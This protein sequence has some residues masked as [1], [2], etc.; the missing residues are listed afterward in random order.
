MNV[1]GESAPAVAAEGLVKTFRD[2]WGRPRAKA[3]RGVSLRVDSGEAV[4]ILGPNGSGKSTT[5]K[6]LLGLLR[7]TSGRALLFGEPPSSAA[8]RARTGYLPEVSNLHKF[9]TP[10]ET[11]EYHGGLLGLG[12][13]DVRA[14][15]PELLDRVG[16][17]REA[18]RRTVGEF[19]KGMARRVALAQALLGDPDLVVLD[20]PTSG[21]DPVGRRDVKDLVRSLAAEGRAVLLSSHLLAEVE[22]VCSRVAI[23]VDGTVRAEGRL[24]DLLENRG[25]VRFTAEGLAPEAADRFRAELEAEAQTVSVDHPSRSLESYFLDVLRAAPRDGGASAAAPAGGSPR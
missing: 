25:A 9:L 5:I 11:L 23:V 1:S 8:A 4:G 6:M 19:S 2:F 21:L 16:L 13:A 7:P 20:E 22:D 12:R 15:I 18:A 24:S 14:R 17:S 3:V 10:A